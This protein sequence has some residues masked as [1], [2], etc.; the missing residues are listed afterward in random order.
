MS[1]N[2][3]KRAEEIVYKR[4]EEKTRQYGDF[5]PSMKRA[6]EM[7]KL[8]MNKDMDP[9]EIVYEAMI[10][11]KRSREAHTHKED[12][13]LDMVAY[14]SS[15]NDYRNMKGITIKDYKLKIFEDILNDGHIVK[16][17]DSLTKELLN[18]QFTFKPYDCL[19]N[20]EGRNLNIDYIKKEFQWYLG[21]NKFDTSITEYAKIWNIIMNEDKS[22]NSNYGVYLIPEFKRIINILIG[23]KHS[24]QAVIYIGNNKNLNTITK[25]YLCTGSIQFLIRN[26]QLTMT[27]H[28]RSNDAIFGLCNDVP[29]FSFYQQMIYTILRDKYYEDLKLGNYTH[30]AN[31]LHVY[32]RH[33]KML[34]KIVK[35]NNF[36]NIDYPKIE[37]EREVYNL[38]NAEYKNYDFSIWLNNYERKEKEYITYDYREKC[39]YCEKLNCSCIFK[40]LN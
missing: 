23:D 34:E 14:I 11:V 4:T 35:C 17:K 25:D 20:F 30:I 29:C 40:T 33:F 1:N 31:S 2:I 13:L 37:N 19:L 36:I 12:N 27:V 39:N 28:M 32:E 6:G 21:A 8:V 3:L 18:Y 7:L 26:N 16:V 9:T 22:F 24:R 5:I 15:L 38:I 10:A